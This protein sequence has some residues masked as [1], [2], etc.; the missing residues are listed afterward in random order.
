MKQII[1]LKNL[2]EIN[3]TNKNIPINA[4]HVFQRQSNHFHQFCFIVQ[5]MWDG[6]RSCQIRRSCR[7]ALIYSPSNWSWYLEYFKSFVNVVPLANSISKYYKLFHWLL[8]FE[9]VIL[10]KFMF[11][12]FILPNVPNSYFINIIIQSYAPM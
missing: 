5:I 4:G 8:H 10:L 3:S 12:L 1:L 11:T 6:E 2:S 9:H 7:V